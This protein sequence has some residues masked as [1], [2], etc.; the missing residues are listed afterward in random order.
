MQDMEPES[1]HSVVSDPPY[2]LAFMGKQWDHAVPGVDYWAEVLRVLKP[3]GYLAA[4]GGTRLY[5]RLTCAIEDAGFEIRDCLM[6]V[7][8]SGFPKSHDVSKAI[9]K[10]AGA[11]RDVIGRVKGC[12][13]NSGEGRYNWNNPDDKID[14][15]FYD[16]TAPA[17]PEAAQWQGWGTALKPAWEPIILARKPFKG[18][19]AGNV[20]EHGT[21]ALNIDG[22][23]VETDDNLGG[24]AYSNNREKS[25]NTIYGDYNR[26]KLDFKNPDGRWPANL[27]HDGSDDALR[28]FHN[29]EGRYF[30]CA[31]ASQ[32]ERNAGLQE[33]P[34][35][36]AKGGGGMNNPEA[37]R[38]YGSL[39][40]PA[41]NF[42][43][44]V[45]PVAL[46]KWLCRMV[47]PPAGI[48]L[49]P[50]CGSGSTLVAAMQEGFRPIGI[51]LEEKYI[52]I[53]RLRCEHE[54]F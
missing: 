24:G 53:A 28:G 20:L 36:Q 54:D 31:K 17:T 3:G 33:L 5:H 25:T 4:F 14:R 47:T 13:S 30:Y 11:E 41:K 37:G 2:G 49:D 50:F 9:D 16:K 10:A 45:K 39:H 12:G 52:E 23:R 38:I 19:V 1:I 42:H 21:G 18:T 6:W 51:D 44:T 32:A 26:I 27:V 8:G 22:C 7:Y 40:T 35:G 48:V 46:M 34:T 43:P 15:R 29:N